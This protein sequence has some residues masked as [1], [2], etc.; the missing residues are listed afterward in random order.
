MYNEISKFLIVLRLDLGMAV[1]LGLDPG[2]SED[3]GDG[4]RKKPKTTNAATGFSAASV[5]AGS[6]QLIAFYFRAPVKAFFRT[7]VDYMAYARAINPRVQANDSWSWRVTT[8]GLLA[9]AVK[10]HGWGFIPNQ[11]LPPLIANIGVG[12]ILYTSYLQFLGALHEPASHSTKRI[13]PPPSLFTTFPAGFAA[14]TVQSVVATPLDA[15][16]MRF[17]V[18][19]MLEGQYKTMWAYGKHKLRD[20]GLRGVFAGWALSFSKESL[21]YGFF[22]ATFEYV[23]QQS[24]LSFIARYYGSYDPLFHPH[25]LRPTS[26][27]DSK[28][29]IKP[30]Y[31]LEPT[32]LLLAGIAASVTQQA[33]QAPLNLIQNNHYQG[34][35]SLDYKS[36]HDPSASRVIAKSY[37]HAYRK[38]FE[39]CQ[40]QAKMAGGWR[41]WLYRGFILNTMKQVPS[42]SAGLI[43]FELVRR[44]YGS[45]AEAVR[46]EKDGYNILL[47]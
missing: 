1:T 30:H 6:A 11:V 13:Y 14:G 3:V 9:H 41:R 22:F 24:Y 2:G 7:R 15:L 42:T 47:S 12:A 37:Y 21:G 27:R 29:V 31:A 40:R 35:E 38:T 36:H 45:Q 4:S 19:D 20:I 10:T 44:K 43:V 17:K 18:S 5:R 32:F 34:L 23:K 16:Q 26:D 28:P 39:Q 8:P 25:P 33:I 46:I